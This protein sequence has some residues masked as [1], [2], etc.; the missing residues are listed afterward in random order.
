MRLVTDMLRRVILCT[1]DANMER[2]ELRKFRSYPVDTVLADRGRY[3]AAALTVVRSYL[4][5][6]CPS[7][8]PPLASFEDWSRLVRS[9]L[10]WLGCADPVDTMEAARADDPSRS[11]LRAVIA[12]WRSTIGADKQMTATELKDRACSGAEDANPMLNKAIAA[13]ASAPGRNE[14]DALRL[15]QWL[16]RNKGRVIDGYKIVGEPD[17][18]SKQM[19]WLLTAIGKAP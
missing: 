18:H 6:D 11:S 8:L 7:L 1:L 13:I 10:V 12:A 9:P 5:A 19:V 4:V 3:I 16:G 17:R 2:P 14:I 15:G